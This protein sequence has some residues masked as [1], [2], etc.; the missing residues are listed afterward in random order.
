[1]VDK[2][3]E[4]KKRWKEENPEKDKQSKRN[5]QKKN[6]KKRSIN[7]KRYVKNNPKKIKAHSLSHHIPIGKFCAICGITENLEK[8]H[9]N[10]DCPMLI[11]TLCKSCHTKIHRGKKK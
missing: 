7:Q 3:Y 4:T 5:W 2:Y 9:P 6:K 1:M 10:Y 8:H 11:I